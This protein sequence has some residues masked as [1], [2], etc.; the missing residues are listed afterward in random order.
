MFRSFRN[1][2][3]Q[4]TE[5]PLNLNLMLERTIIGKL[6]AAITQAQILGAINGTVRE[7]SAP[8]DGDVSQ[9]FRYT[10]FYITIL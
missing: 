4:Q 1:H 6:Q 10:Q 5:N 7:T 8:D 3:P 9:R 2:Q